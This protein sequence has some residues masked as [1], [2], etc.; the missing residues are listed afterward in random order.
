M[1]KTTPGFQAT[2]FNA[3]REKYPYLD[4]AIIVQ[5]VGG[6][7]S[8]SDLGL[9]IGQIQDIQRIMDGILKGIGLEGIP[10]EVN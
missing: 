9:G 7:I 1:R 8:L 4:P 5:N 6:G 10:E 3:I 2:A